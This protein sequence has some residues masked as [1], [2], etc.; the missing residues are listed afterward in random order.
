MKP[1]MYL[2]KLDKDFHSKI[3]K[4]AKERKMTMD[5]F[6]RNATQHYLH[7]FI[8]ELDDDLHS[9]VKERSRREGMPMDLF[10]RKAIDRYLNF[11]LDKDLENLVEKKGIESI[12]EGLKKLE[13]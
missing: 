10:I 8:L 3:K 2:L 5:L 12:K 11:F 6:I 4:R 9:E 1:K 7:D 13:K